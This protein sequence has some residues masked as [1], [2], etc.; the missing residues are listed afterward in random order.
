M[1]NQHH[2]HMRERL[3]SHPPNT[4]GSRN[5]DSTF[6]IHT[7]WVKKH[8]GI[9]TALRL[10]MSSAMRNQLATITLEPEMV[11]RRNWHQ[12][13]LLLNFHAKNSPLHAPI[14]LKH[15]NAS[16][17]ISIVRANAKQTC[18]L[19]TVHP[20]QNVSP[21]RTLV[22]PFSVQILKGHDPSTERITHECATLGCS[23]SSCGEN[24]TSD[25]KMSDARA[26][27]GTART[28][29]YI[30]ICNSWHCRTQEEEDL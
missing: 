13:T 16:E 14:S 17:L 5:S 12:S 11:K 18:F 26:E 9:K 19:W 24:R 4:R 25:I 15:E 8:G 3:Q 22:M 20:C 10:W 1:R 28:T 23:I 2:F 7:K 30:C 27:H 21:R 29:F 6:Q